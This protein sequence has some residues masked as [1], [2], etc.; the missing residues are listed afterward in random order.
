MGINN[1]PSVDSRWTK[2]AA[3]PLSGFE[4]CSIQVID[5]HTV[6]LG[7]D[8]NPWTNDLGAAVGEI[9]WS[10]KGQIAVFRQT[11]NTFMPVGSIT[12]V[13]S[14]RFTTTDVGPLI[15]VRQGFQVRVTACAAVPDLLTYQYTI[16]SAITSNLAFTRD[17]EAEADMGVTI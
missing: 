17:F 13:R 10:G 5:P 7:D 2:H 6:D 16:T 11:L 12:Q 14:I 15:P 3:G 1:R 8:Y 4:T 9:V